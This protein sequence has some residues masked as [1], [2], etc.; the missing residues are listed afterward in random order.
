MRLN[1]TL[2]REN[3]AR[4]ATNTAR[5][6]ALHA[7]RQTKAFDGAHRSYAPRQGQDAE[8]ERLPDV[9]QRIQLRA[10]EILAEVRG[11]YVKLLDV[12]ADKEFGNVLASGTVVVD[13]K[14]LIAK[15]PVPY[16]LFLESKLDELDE[17]LAGTP[18]LD[19]SKEWVP[20]PNTGDFRSKP[21]QTV[22]T[23]K[24]PRIISAAKATDKH[25]EQYI[26]HDEDI[27][28]GDYTDTAFSG[29][30]Q[31]ADVKAMRERLR[32]VKEAVVLAREEANTAQVEEH[33][34]GEDILNVIF[35]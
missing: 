24:T 9:E 20:D 25:P 27:P 13:G 22:R 3:D 31:A 6:T 1:Q 32:K 35:G 15:A 26:R 17:V 2:K 33:H 5:A 7:F 8:T 16:L 23:R 18:V 34:V 14:T 11:E 12:T 28:V 21:V 10:P 4:T 29:K 30:M 19:A